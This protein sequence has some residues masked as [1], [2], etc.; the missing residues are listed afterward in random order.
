MKNLGLIAFI[1]P[2]FMT[3]YTTTIGNTVYY[4]SKKYIEEDPLRAIKLL[5]HEYVHIVDSQNDE[6]FS[7][8]Y[9]MPQIFVLLII[10]AIF[11]IGW[12][13]LLFL[14]FLLPIPAYHRMVYEKRGYTMS[15]FM[16]NEIFYDF[17]KEW[18]E[19]LLA[20]AA[21]SINAKYF[22]GPGY[23]FMWPFGVNFDKEVESI[24]SGKILKTDPIYAEVKAA[25]RKIGGN[26][27]DI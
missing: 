7:I 3:E 27:T 11:I 20:K 17:N 21:E 18:R 25:Y 14:L 9:L 8:K 13:S 24:L 26:E 2:L 15:L 19:Q 12:W 10:P 1:N 22:K 4:P 5:A 16:L 6:L 23:Y